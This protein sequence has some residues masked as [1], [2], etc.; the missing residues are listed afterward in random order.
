MEKE[1]TTP[2]CRHYR[3]AK[4]IRR[5]YMRCLELCWLLFWSNWYHLGKKLR[6]LMSMIALNK[7]DKDRHLKF[8]FYHLTRGEIYTVL[9]YLK[10]ELITKRRKI[11]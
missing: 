10:K 9:D 1:S 6:D 4:V 11:S 7:A 5:D 2:D 3:W 8:M